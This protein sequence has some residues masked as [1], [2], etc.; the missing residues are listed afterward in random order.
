[1]TI[2]ASSPAAPSPEETRRNTHLSRL[3]AIWENKIGLGTFTVVNHTSIGLR[4]I[5]T[6]FIF[7]LV[8]G[9]LSM[10]LRSQLSFADNDLMDHKAYSE[11]FTMHGT[12]MMFFFAVPVMEGVALYLLPKMLGT[13]DLIYPRLSAYGYWCYLFGGLLLYS[14]FL[15]DAVPDGGW[16]MYV[17][18]NNAEFSPGSNV[19]FWLLGVTFA[20]ISAVAAGVELIVAI[21]KTRTAG[22]SINRM[23]LYAWYILVTAFMIVFG[24]PPLILASI[25]LEIER[26]FGLPFY[27]VANGGDPLLWQHLFWIFGHPEVYIIFLPAAGLVTTM[28]PTFARHPIVGYNWVVLAVIGTGFISFGLWVHHMFTVGIPLLS[29]AF[30][31]AASMAVAIPSG[32]QVFA[33]IAT[34]WSGRPVMSTPML[35]ILGFLF[36]FVLGGLTGVMVALVPFDWQVHDSHFVVAHLHYVLFGGMVFPLFAAFYYWLPLV[37]GRA[38]SQHLSK[39]G[40]WTIFI[41]FN[42][43]FL[44]MHLTGLMGMPRRVYTYLPGLGWDM[45]NLIST[46]GGF[47][48]AIGVAILVVDVVLHFFHGRRTPTNLWNAGTLEWAVQTPAPPYNFASQPQVHDREPLWSNPRLPQEIDEGRHLLNHASVTRREILW[49]SITHAHPQAIAILPGNALVPLVAAVLT[50]LLFIGFLSKQYWLS[51]AGAIATLAALLYWAWNNGTSGPTADME[52]APGMRLPVHFKIPLTTGWWGT[53]I[54][55]LADGTLFI[56]LLFAYYFLWTVSAEWPPPG[57]REIS[58]ALPLLAFA[59]LLIAGFAASWADACNSRADGKKH[60][61]AI[62]I[63]YGATMFFGLAFIV[64]QIA[65]LHTSEVP[66]REHAYGALIYTVSGVQIVHVGIGMLMAGFVLMR[67]RF[68]YL[69]PDQPGEGKIVTLFWQYTM[70]QWLLGFATIHVFPMFAGG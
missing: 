70:L 33:W 43:T 27:N 6:G 9:I 64:L 35:Y 49:T 15:F 37:S 7:F 14:S 3:Q 8:G 66:A 56:S 53:L 23:P 50:S 1:M 32:I 57:Y 67:V 30:F 51:V 20:E 62:P 5:I 44:P 59:A 21:L 55:L 41:G 54:A 18:L 45:L 24:F 34:L 36:I 60:A 12:T 48:S 38:P 52:V 42:V 29:L 39:V 10:W 47:V 4:F 68:G 46:V 58:L 26:A 61:G 63:A 19:D 17:P 40:F 16:F 11:A 28:L 22:M 31:S 65:A 25:L 13:R 2:P 69:R